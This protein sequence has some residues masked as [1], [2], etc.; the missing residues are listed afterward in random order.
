MTV[1]EKSSERGRGGQ[2]KHR[3]S[4]AR[5]VK[6]M[7]TVAGDHSGDGAC[8]PSETEDVLKRWS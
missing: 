5:P 8:V 6:S 2:G 7:T 4:K 3:S 1:A